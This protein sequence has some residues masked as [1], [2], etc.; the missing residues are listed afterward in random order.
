MR[1]V[2]NRN[3]TDPNKYDKGSLYEAVAQKLPH[4]WKVP[5]LLPDLHKKIEKFGKKHCGDEY[6]LLHKDKWTIPLKSQRAYLT[7]YLM[8]V[9]C[10][11]IPRQGPEFYNRKGWNKWEPYEEFLGD[12]NL[13]RHLTGTF[14]KFGYKRKKD[15]KTTRIVI[16]KFGGINQ[17]DLARRVYQRLHG[18]GGFGDA[19]SLTYN[20]GSS[21]R[22]LYTFNDPIPMELLK[23]S[24]DKAFEY[25]PGSQDIEILP[26][27]LDDSVEPIPFGDQYQPLDPSILGTPE[28]AKREARYLTEE[29]RW[30]EMERVFRKEK[31]R[32]YDSL[33]DLIP[34]YNLVSTK[35]GGIPSNES[36]F[37]YTRSDKP[38]Y[39]INHFK[40]TKYLFEHTPPTK[41]RKRLTDYQ[42]FNFNIAEA[43]PN[44][45]NTLTSQQMDKFMRYIVKTK[46]FKEYYEK[47]EHRGPR[48]FLN[49]F[50]LIAVVLNDFYDAYRRGKTKKYYYP[51]S[52]LRSI[53]SR[54]S[55]Y[56][57]ELFFP[58]FTDLVSNYCRATYKVQ[59]RAY[60]MEIFG[61]VAR[62]ILTMD[63]IITRSPF[64][65]ISFNNYVSN[66]LKYSNYIVYNNII[67]YKYLKYSIICRKKRLASKRKWW[68]KT[69]GKVR[70][71]LLA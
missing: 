28:G 21:I 4:I 9:T 1:S 47:Y 23:P 61:R 30:T 37:R 58:I 31:Y 42:R 46:R 18:T 26:N 54:Y 59:C 69:Y 60:D 32:I 16:L 65:E 19:P 70:P 44:G 38:E 39:F 51:S 8:A 35:K 22:F 5:H 34:C 10:T 71:R 41:K 6:R 62:N 67:I 25:M 53:D 43:F 49:T 55:T 56:F 13:S 20:V 17:P 14:C 36:S 7:D 52:R 29:E 57:H 3:L 40:G 27:P 2:K 11:D 12:F 45:G 68:N 48:F 50:R 64:Y 24:F 33:T 66:L 15:I 63:K